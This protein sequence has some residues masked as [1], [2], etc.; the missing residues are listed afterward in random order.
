LRSLLA[1]G[2]ALALAACTGD[3]AGEDDPKPNAPSSTPA[4]GAVQQ[5]AELTV[6]AEDHTGYDRDLFPHWSDQGDG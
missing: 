6:A 1:A 3:G 5:L 2:A 4:T